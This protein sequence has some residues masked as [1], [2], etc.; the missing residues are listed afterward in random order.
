MFYHPNDSKA[1]I[2]T[3]HLI[4]W[5]SMFTMIGLFIFLFRDDVKIPQ[6]EVT[7]KIDLHN[8]INVCAPEEDD[9]DKKS[10]FEF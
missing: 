8:K 9:L 10:F 7:L 3:K 2:I 5:I 6:E 1:T 4:F